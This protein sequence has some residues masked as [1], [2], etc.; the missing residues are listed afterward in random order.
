MLSKSGS[1]EAPPPLLSDEGDCSD[2][3]R[4]DDEKMTEINQPSDIK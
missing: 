3:I 2:G 1:D 4:T